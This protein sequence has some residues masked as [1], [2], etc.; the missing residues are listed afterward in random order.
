MLRSLQNLSHLG[1][2][3][4]SFANSITPNTKGYKHERAGDFRSDTLFLSG[5]RR[6]SWRRWL[7]TLGRLTRD[8]M[9]QFSCHRP[10][11]NLVKQY[12]E[13]NLDNGLLHK[14]RRFDRATVNEA[15]SFVVI[16]DDCFRKRQEKFPTGWWRSMLFFVGM[17]WFT[18][19]GGDAK[20]YYKHWS[21]MWSS[22][23]F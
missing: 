13:D 3:R 15:H 16:A 6:S 12:I 22:R 10:S 7:A 8:Q 1:G 14:V 18:V 2:M 4:S 11:L 17:Y 9:N 19:A 20:K 23:V 21:S 5:K